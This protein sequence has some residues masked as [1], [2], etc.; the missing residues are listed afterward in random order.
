MVAGYYVWRRAYGRPAAVRRI[1]RA[2]QVFEFGG[3]EVL[4]YSAEVVAPEITAPNQVLVGIASV[5]V[6]PVETYIRAGAREHPLPYIPGS[7]GA[8]KVLQVGEDVNGL[9]VGQRVFLCRGPDGGPSGT[10]ASCTVAPASCVRPLPDRLTFQQGAGVGIPY[11]TAWHA[12]MQRAAAGR[13]SRVLVHGASGAVGL[14]AVQIARHHGMLV[15]GTAGTEEGMK[16]V[17]E[18][19]AEHVFNHRTPGYTQEILAAS[20]GGVD[21]IL[22]MLANV[23]LATDLTLLRFRGRVVVIGSRGSIQIDPRL[24]MGPETSI[25]GC[26]LAAVTKEEWEE[27]DLRIGEGLEAGWMTPIVDKTYP[28]E[29][30]GRAHEDIINSAGARG[31]IVLEV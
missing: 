31:N 10:Y 17:Q 19:G 14:A 2:I 13:G 26:A 30:A 27:L 12:L 7:D 22:E 6:N 4:K 1:M 21:V 11:F 24:T 20:N 29:Q 28:L 16:L 3:P 18:Q 9:Q 8:G 23:N 5:G 15:M 25:M